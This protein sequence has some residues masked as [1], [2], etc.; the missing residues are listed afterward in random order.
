MSN[1]QNLSKIEIMKKPYNRKSKI[2]ENTE[3]IEYPK[4]TTSQE[5]KRLRTKL[6]QAT[7]DS[8][9]YI[10]PYPMFQRRRFWEYDLNPITG[11]PPAQ[12]KANDYS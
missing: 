12:S 2:S 11:M 8:N 9:E 10:T 5:R 4:K 1:E 6:S 3:K 7:D